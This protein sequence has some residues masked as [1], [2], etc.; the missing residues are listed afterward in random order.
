MPRRNAITVNVRISEFVAKLTTYTLLL[1]GAFIIMIPF[2]WMLSTSLKTP[3]QVFVW[4]IKWVPNP[5]R[6]QNYIEALTK[7]PFARYTLNTTIISA[8]TILGQLIASSLAAYSFARLRWRGRD[9]LFSLVLSTMMLPQSVTLVPK[10][11]LFAQI[12]WVNTFLPL[13]VPEFGGSAFAV[14]LMRQFFRTLPKEL[15]EA[16][17]IDGCDRF[18]IYS[19]IILP[20]SKPVLGIVAI[21]AF[22][23]SWNDFINPLIYLNDPR[24][25]TLTLGLRAFQQEFT[26]DWHLL[27]AA[28]TVVMLPLLI[29]FAVAQKY[30]IQG[31]VFTGIR[32]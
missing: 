25:W 18:T 7:R 29:V 11:V 6:W 5:I 27:M 30:F 19:K 22:K 2:V 9:L 15:D 4:P 21:N 28:S 3:D 14:F 20:L 10:F 13:V 8:L 16:A 24:L 1:L 23:Y 32:G 17:K 26:V 12:N 31:I